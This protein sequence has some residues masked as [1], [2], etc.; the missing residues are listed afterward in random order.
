MK[1]NMVLTEG[2]DYLL[3]LSGSYPISVFELYRYTPE[4]R[5]SIGRYALVNGVRAA[6]KQF[7][8]KLGVRLS[9]STVRS[10]KDS[11]KMEAN[12]RK[13]QGAD[14]GDIDSLPL[15][16]RGRDLLLGEELDRKVQ[17]Y[18]KNVR[19]SGGVVSARIAMAAARG[20]LLSYDKNMLAEFGGPIEL[21]RNWAYSLLKRMKFVKRK[22]ST[23]KSKY[24]EVDVK[25]AKQKFLDE[26]VN[27]VIIEEIPPELIMN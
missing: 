24:R 23:A 4:Q 17:E 5:A 7:S 26:V 2:M 19:S 16:K 1:R 11:Y 8:K 12:E 10:I 13:R 18:L 25:A 27:T 9:E 20:I 6:A 21:N 22:A 3:L 14:V 15:K